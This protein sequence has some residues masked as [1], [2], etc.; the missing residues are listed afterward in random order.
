MNDLAGMSLIVRVVT[1]WLLGLIILFSVAVA[2]FGHLTPGGGFVGGVILACG[3]VLCTLAF[4]GRTYPAAA[5]ARLSSSLDAVGALSFLVVALLGYI[6]GHFFARWIAMGEQ[7][8]LGSTPFIILMN[9][10][11]LL[12]VGAGVFA[13]FVA[14]VAFGRLISGE[15]GGH[16]Q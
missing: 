4:G 12:K 11:I 8:T 15:E 1:R 13:G 6:A 14:L 5:F 10:A 7:F 9:L 2:L 3:F 16:Q